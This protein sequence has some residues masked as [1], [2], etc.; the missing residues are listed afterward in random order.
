MHLIG[1]AQYSEPRAGVRCSIEDVHQHETT[2]QQ[3]IDEASII[4]N[5]SLMYPPSETEHG[6]LV[7][8]TM[9]P[10]PQLS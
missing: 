10:T 1:N 9:C 3:V 2:G 4:G 6:I 5:K 7:I 8:G